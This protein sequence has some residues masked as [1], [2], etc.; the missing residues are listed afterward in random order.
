MIKLKDI[1]QEKK[2][3]LTEVDKMSPEQMKFAKPIFD[4]AAKKGGTKVKKMY[5]SFQPTAVIQAF[6]FGKDGGSMASIWGH[7]LNKRDAMSLKKAWEQADMDIKMSEF[8]PKFFLRPEDQYITLA[9]AA[10]FTGQKY[11]R[12]EYDKL[13]RGR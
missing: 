9:D 7:A 11:D 3:T 1:L 5:M 10:R 2:D 12:S 13:F 8:K 6:A 4:A